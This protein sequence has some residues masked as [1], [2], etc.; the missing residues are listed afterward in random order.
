[1]LIQVIWLKGSRFTYVVKKLMNIVVLGKQR[2]KV[3]WF[4]IVFNNLYS[5]L[6]DLSA[7]TKPNASRDNIKFEV[8]QVVDIL[9]WN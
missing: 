4:A 6:Q 5:K 3:N 1:M 7:P 8:A 9:F 2:V